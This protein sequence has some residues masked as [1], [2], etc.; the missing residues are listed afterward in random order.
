VRAMGLSNSA[1][2]TENKKKYSVQFFD[3]DKK[4]GKI[5]EHDLERILR[6]FPYDCLCYETK[7]GIHFISFA[8]LKGMRRTKAKALECCKLLGEQD[9]WCSKQDLTLRVSP[10]W[11][12]RKFHKMHEIVSK[13]PKFKAIAKK[14]NKY[15][16]SKNHLDFYRKFMKLPEEVYHLYDDC[17]KFDYKIKIYN[18]KTRD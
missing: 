7:H 16:I 5:T 12:P 2:D 14:P 8:L 10:K 1:W 4:N 6:I 9:Y 15:R 18:Y 13:R 11:K 3:Y 17:E